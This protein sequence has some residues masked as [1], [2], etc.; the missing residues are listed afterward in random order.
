MSEAQD[1]PAE[2][3]P[4]RYQRKRSQSLFAPNVTALLT[5]Q[6]IGGISEKVGSTHPG[7]QSWGLY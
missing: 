2:E 6:H 1:K 4:A 5:G 3:D 7:P